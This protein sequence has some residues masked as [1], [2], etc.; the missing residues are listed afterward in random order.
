MARAG[1]VGREARSFSTFTS[2]FTES[3]GLFDYVDT[4]EDGRHLNKIN[5]II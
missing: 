1:L 4:A 3:Y 5:G 2:S